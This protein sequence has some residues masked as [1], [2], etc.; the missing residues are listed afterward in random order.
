MVRNGMAAS[1][2][3]LQAGHG[4]SQSISTVA[5]RLWVRVPLAFTDSIVYFFRCHKLK[6]TVQRKKLASAELFGVGTA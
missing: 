2:S 1:A 5:K 6:K 4:G 3:I